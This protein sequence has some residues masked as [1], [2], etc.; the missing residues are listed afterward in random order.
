MRKTLRRRGLASLALTAALAAAGM[1]AAHAAQKPSIRVTA[2][3]TQPVFSYQDAVREYVD[4]QSS[5]DSDGDGKK[6]LIRVDIVRPKES[7]PRFKVPVIMDE[8]PYYDNLGR[9]NESERKTYDAQGDPAKFP[10]YYDNY[11]V[12]RGYAVLE[13]DMDGTTKSDGCPTSG[14]PSDVLGG[15]A[16]V[17]WLNGRAKAFD[18][19]G[20]QVRADWTNGRT[21]MIGKS[22]DGTLANGVAA[23]GVKGLETIVPISAISSWYDYSRMGGTLLS[24]HEEDGLADTV[25]TD[26][27]AKCAAVRSQL[28]A[29]QDDAT[30]NY[31]EFWKERDYRSGTVTDVRKVHA[32]VFATQ[33][34]N[35][36]NVKPSQ[37]STWWSALA[38]QGV[39]RKVWLSQYGHVDPFDYRRDV[40]V[41]TLHQWFDHWLWR[42]PNDVMKQPRAD[43]ETGPDQWTTQADWPAPAASPVTLRPQKDGSLGLRASSGTGTYTDTEQSESSLVADPT[44]GAPYRLAYATAPLAHDVRVS[45]TPQVDLR[46]KL[47]K[48][49]ANLGA[50]LVDYG[51]DTRV[52]YL[53][54][55]EG[56]KTLTTEDCHGES[57]AVDD[58]CYRQVVTDTIT[59][60]VNVVAR[61]YVDA[62]NRNSLSAPSA[63]RPGSY[64]RVRWD[65]LP[66]DYRFKAGHRLALVLLGTDGDVQSDTATGASVTVDLAG[67]G[68]T[69]PVVGG[70][71]A[72]GHLPAAPGTWRAPSH[73]VLPAP[74]KSFR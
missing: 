18:A 37:F 48:P 3:G 57:T 71:G 64:Y 15:K 14:G 67:S 7:G 62:Q 47:D 41:D 36:L 63:L 28:A 23:T 42:I 55:G 9:G 46:V 32:A 59:S 24:R 43:V 69:L 34:L 73:V 17:D 38:K 8:S 52:N 58:A 5:V 11:F 13:V 29:G 16:V 1:P 70:A 35:D 74:H 68:I 27:S 72:L 53:G 22:Y 31:N 4:V 60:D 65:T 20:R 6:D 12:P 39:P 51:T 56:V 66:Q 44:T 10:L 45:G 54:G 25:D 61:G 33:G 19:Q 26:P 21:G 2:D 30:G 49:T 50:L 40:W